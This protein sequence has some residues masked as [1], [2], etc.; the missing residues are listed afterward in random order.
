MTVTL[1]HRIMGEG[2]PFLI[3]HGLFG[4]SD[5]WQSF[6]RQLAGHGYQVILADLRNHGHSAHASAHTYP[7]MAADIAGLINELQLEQA[8]VLGHSMG[9]K[10]TLRVLCDYPGLIQKAVI[11][12]I[13]P[14]AYPVHHREILDALRRV[15]PQSLRSRTE[16][17]S[18]LRENI[19]D[20][21]TRQFLLKNLYRKEDG[22]LDWRFNLAVID[23]QIEEV[24]E[25]SWPETPVQ[26]P[27]LFVKGDKSAYIDPYRMNEILQG[28]PKAELV[29]I[30]GAGHWVHADQPALLLEEVL[31]FA[32]Q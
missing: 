2:K 24:G 20:Q 11:V 1:H 26:T 10:A 21:G 3:F 15:H 12:D 16:A 14:W 9:G 32:N 17:E 4:M 7:A 13:A 22:T 5:N 18:I 19:H 31:K 30:P 23:A 6:G 27:V 8:I 29:S 28:Y 25:A